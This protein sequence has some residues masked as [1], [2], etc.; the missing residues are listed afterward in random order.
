MQKAHK[1]CCRGGAWYC[2][3]WEHRSLQKQN[4][5]KLPQNTYI[6]IIQLKMNLE[7]VTSKT[8]NIIETVIMQNFI[9]T[10]LLSSYS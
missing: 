7:I 9:W 6:I 10:M 4:K 1:V 8:I 3:H 2:V 5:T